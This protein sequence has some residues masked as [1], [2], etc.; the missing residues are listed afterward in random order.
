MI[1]G[2]QQECMKQRG[3]HAGEEQK[4]GEACLPSISRRECASLM[5]AL[6]K[7]CAMG[8]MPYEMRAVRPRLYGRGR[9]PRAPAGAPVRCAT[10]RAGMSIPRAKQSLRLLRCAARV[11]RKYDAKRVFECAR[12]RSATLYDETRAQKVR[13]RR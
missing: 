4:R 2:R 12:D 7:I 13:R 5:R 9:A 10:L 8:K 6:R 11:R 1:D 3:R